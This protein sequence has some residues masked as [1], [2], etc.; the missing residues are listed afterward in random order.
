MNF[1]KVLQTP[2]NLTRVID[3]FFLWVQ[4]FFF[5]YFLCFQPT[6]IANKRAKNPQIIFIQF[7]LF[8]LDF[9]TNFKV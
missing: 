5:G 7:S 6:L 1:V 2:N 9:Y 8:S 3:G 4:H